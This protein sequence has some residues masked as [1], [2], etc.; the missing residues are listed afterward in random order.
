LHFETKGTDILDLYSY[1]RETLKKNEIADFLAENADIM[2]AII[3]ES[4]C[5]NHMRIVLQRE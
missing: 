2:Q 1:Y 4:G 3:D 5:A